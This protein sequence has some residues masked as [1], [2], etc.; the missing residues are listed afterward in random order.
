MRNTMKLKYTINI[1]DTTNVPT[2]PNESV[3]LVVTSPPYMDVKAYARSDEN[4]I[5]NYKDT[6]YYELMRKVYTECYRMLKPGRT[7]VTNV[8]DVTCKKKDGKSGYLLLGFETIKLLEEIGF[9]HKETVM[10]SKGR[11]RAKGKSPPGTL[12]YPPQPMLLANFEHCIIVRKPGKPKIEVS[13]EAQEASKMNTEFLKEV[14]YTSW[15]VKAETDLGWHI[16]PFPQELVSRFIRLYSFVSETVYDPFL[17]SGSTMLA[18]MS[19]R[20]SCIGTEIGYV[21]HH[22]IYSYWLDVVKER[23]RW[24]AQSITGDDIEYTINDLG[25]G[26]SRELL[27]A[28][29]LKVLKNNSEMEMEET[30]R[31]DRIEW[32]LNHAEMI[33]GMSVKPAEDLGPEM[34]Y[35]MKTY[36][37]Q[38][39]LDDL[40][41]KKE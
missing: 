18:S 9:I 2:V 36:K 22:P 40:V 39:S 10:W 41:E 25:T 29:R 24:G 21:L 6:K 26:A 31:E 34:Y 8:A 12:P 16:A 19:F 38:L 14:L 1:G 37:K 32:H 7:L 28:E 3:H 5:G 13:N 4:N 20:R 23:L 17:G 35:D 11:N 33:E 27:E 30:D 15:Y